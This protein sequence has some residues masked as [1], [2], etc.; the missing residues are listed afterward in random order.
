MSKSKAW[1]VAFTFTVE[2]RDRHKAR[3]ILARNE[4]RV[5]QELPDDTTSFHRKQL[6]KAFAA[7]AAVEWLI[8]KQHIHLDKDNHVVMGNQENS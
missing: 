4:P 6:A 7:Q 2:P 1:T 3:V 5:H 8:A